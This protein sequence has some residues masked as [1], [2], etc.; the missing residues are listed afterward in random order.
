MTGC[1]Q[2]ESSN[3]T[4]K[5]FHYISEIVG[6]QPEDYLFRMQLYLV[7]DRD[8]NIVLSKTSNV[9]LEKDAYYEI[10]IGALGNSKCF[11]R[12]GGESQPLAEVDIA[13]TLTGYERK[14]TIEVKSSEFG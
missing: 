13:N 4:Y 9:D 12:R 14:F 7:G 11:I 10:V 2:Y 5:E 6:A 8:A 3:Y 1:K